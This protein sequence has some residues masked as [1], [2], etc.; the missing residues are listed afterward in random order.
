MKHAL[1][2]L[3]YLAVSSVALAEMGP[4]VLSKYKKSETDWQQDFYK[5]R[6]NRDEEIFFRVDSYQINLNSIFMSLI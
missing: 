1:S 2:Q 3:S 4:E 5:R 6:K